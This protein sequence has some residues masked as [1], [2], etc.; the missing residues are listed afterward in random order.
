M[1]CILINHTYNNIFI[2]I[3]V[4]NINTS[5]V[6]RNNV[7]TKEQINY[8]RLVCTGWAIRSSHLKF[9]KEKIRN[10]IHQKLIDTT[11]EMITLNHLIN[12]GNVKLQYN[13]GNNNLLYIYISI[14]QL[15]NEDTS[16]YFNDRNQGGLS[17][18]KPEFNTWGNKLLQLIR[19]NNNMNKYGKHVAKHIH[20]VITITNKTELKTLFTN[21]MILIFPNEQSFKDQ[22][23]LVLTTIYN[24]ITSKIIH[25]RTNQI[26]RSYSEEH[27][28]R[29]K[30]NTS[31]LLRAGL[32]AT[33]KRKRDVIT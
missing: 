24:V 6:D 15:D 29:C 22:N 16:R 26:V 1:F 18:L 2:K 20:D 27:F 9:K 25:V 33:L 8:Q 30:G 19:D 5:V 23:N 11:K 4:Y 10:R 14:L 28:S 12:I 7:L 3:N 32:K 31:V 13:I 17:M 21:A